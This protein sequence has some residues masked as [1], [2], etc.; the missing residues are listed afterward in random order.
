[1]LSTITCVLIPVFL[2]T[3][4]L[5]AFFAFAAPSG[6]IYN[7]GPTSSKPISHSVLLSNRMLIQHIVPTI[8]A[9][10]TTGSN[11]RRKDGFAEARGTTRT[12]TVPHLKF[13]EREPSLLRDRECVNHN[14]YD[15]IRHSDDNDDADDS[16]NEDDNDDKEDYDSEEEHDGE[17]D[18]DS[19][20]EDDDE[21]Y[22]N[23]VPIRPSSGLNRREDHPDMEDSDE[24]KPGN[25]VHRNLKQEAPVVKVNSTTNMISEQNL[26]TKIEDWITKAV[27]DQTQQLEKALDEI[28]F[29][30][31]MSE[32]P[33]AI[34]ATTTTARMAGYMKT[35]TKKQKKNRNHL[36][37][38]H[39]RVEMVPDIKE[40]FLEPLVLNLRADIRNTLLWLCQGEHGSETIADDGAARLN[41]LEVVTSHPNGTIY[42]KD[43]LD[44]TILPQLWNCIGTKIHVLLKVLGDLLWTR[45]GQLKE[46]TIDRLRILIGLP[47]NYS[48]V[49]WGTG[50]GTGSRPG[51]M[52]KMEE[53][54]LDEGQVGEEEAFIATSSKIDFAERLVDKVVARL[55]TLY[56][57]SSSSSSLSSNQP[58]SADVHSTVVNNA[59][60]KKASTKDTNKAD[61]HDGRVATVVTIQD[62]EL[63]NVS[64]T[65]A[66]MRK[67]RSWRSKHER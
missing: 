41:D 8:E 9:T 6:P 67:R 46:F 12:R 5:G 34:T 23:L 28:I 32:S 62:Q 53:M 26:T 43:I 39:I 50:T 18:N 19:K 42:F 56:G 30:I 16:D 20:D 22:Q 51:G 38:H 10:T 4:S 24:Y 44:P 59:D 52:M 40:L 25:K 31:F 2:V 7:L 48:F 66:V 33:E 1:M 15:R 60:A 14:K 17:Y 55:E 58:Y 65:A 37:K 45:I 21:Q 54:M 64:S 29:G 35:K 36:Q 13:S 3:L 11:A 61:Q 49:D 47:R 63:S 57:P 27:D